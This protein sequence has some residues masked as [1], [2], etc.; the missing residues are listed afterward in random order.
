MAA[1]KF[2]TPDE[3]KLIAS[4][5]RG[6]R[7]AFGE[8][9]SIYEKLVYNTVRYNISGNEDALDVSQEVFIKI[10]RYIGKYRGDCRFSTWV[11]KICTNTCLD[12]LRRSKL[13]SFERMPVFT[14]KDGDETE[15]EYADESVA[16]SPER[17]LEQNE[18]VRTVREAISRLS[19]EQREV[20]M[21]RDIEGY[22]YEEISEMLSI[23]IGT[24][25]SRL[26]RARNNL[27]LIIAEM[28]GINTYR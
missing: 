2:N 10:W 11:Y 25:K 27:R 22:A 4:A 24:V 16:A 5:A 3:E 13:N 14:D 19:E 18:N 21:L 12:F 15:V 17:S 1:S 9:V 6:D 23:E 7:E 8:L 20:I 28:R 26:S